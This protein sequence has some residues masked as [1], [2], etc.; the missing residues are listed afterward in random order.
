MPERGG[1][2]AEVRERG[3]A[4]GGA[5]AEVPES[6][7]GDKREC[8]GASAE[9]P[10]FCGGDKPRA[11]VPELRRAEVPEFSGGDKQL[12][13]PFAD[14]LACRDLSASFLTTPS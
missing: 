10:E 8:G 3:G 4:R 7:G 5:R 2:S 11:E 9:V 6:C 12:D 13:S 14:N 1:A